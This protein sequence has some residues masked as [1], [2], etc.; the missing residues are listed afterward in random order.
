MRTFIC[1][2]AA[3]FL[4]VTGASD[5]FADAE[6]GQFYFSAMGSYMDDDKNRDV[7][8]DINGG[9]ISLGYAV[10]DVLNIEGALSAAAAKSADQDILTL[11]V[12]L[13]RVFRRAE[14]FSPYLHVGV[15]YINTDPEGA[16]SENDGAMYSA[17]A[18]FLVDMFRSN[19]A[20]RGEWRHRLD[21]SG[22]Q[23]LN[24]NLFSLG[25]QIPF[26]DSSPKFVD[27]DGDGVA[28][29]MDRCP[30]SPPGV[31]VDAYGCEVD[32]DGDGVKDSMDKCPGTPS[33]VAVDA[34]GCPLDSDGDGVTDDKDKCPNTPAG[35]KVDMNGCELDSDKDGVVDRLDE[36][37]NT[38]PGVQV[39]IKGC[40]IKDE[41][42]LRGVN[43]QTNS[44]RLLPSAS[45][46]LDDAAATLRKNPTIK[47]EV[48]GHTDSDGSAEYN[49]GLSA[50]RAATV[51]DYLAAKGVAMDRMTTRGYGESQPIA[52]NSTREGKAQNRRVVL[53]ILER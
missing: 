30:N 29:G 5:A 25:L 44:D 20:L 51:R 2:V 15:G 1:V 14:R 34:S 36:C 43:F 53:V 33:G 28:D 41:I 18:G 46:I 13:Q 3:T 37:P 10:N 47:V 45:A 49:E 16:V 39:D 17:G 32:S 22:S 40:E 38:K 42:A 31:T 26:G 35:A 48:A 21:T 11:G 8:D 52:D 19:V 24:D 12:D 27:S 9:Q 23:N 50:R 6:A 7:N 4:A